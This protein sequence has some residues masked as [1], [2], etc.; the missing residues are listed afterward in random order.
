ML[1]NF[2]LFLQCLLCFDICITQE[3][4]WLIAVH[5]FPIVFIHVYIHS[6]AHYFNTELC[7]HMLA[8]SMLRKSMWYAW[9][10]LHRGKQ[11]HYLDS[12]P[13][14]TSLS[15]LMALKLLTQ[16]PMACL[17]QTYYLYMVDILTFQHQ[18]REREGGWKVRKKRE[19][20]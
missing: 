10:L 14:I 8:I 19:V 4:F 17:S 20:Y 9:L 18:Q 3:H 16:W 2:V 5:N 12:S 6:F 1:D 15:G 13:K 7:I 11:P